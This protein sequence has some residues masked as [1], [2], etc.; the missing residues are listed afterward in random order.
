MEELKDK[1]LAV[2]TRKDL[3]DVLS[4]PL[5][6][7]NYYCKLKQ[8]SKCYNYFYIRKKNGELRL[9]TS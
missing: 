8:S 6:T 5:G 2:K 9:I 1:F 4:V 7:L 3:A